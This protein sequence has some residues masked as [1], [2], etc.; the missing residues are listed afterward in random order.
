M[1]NK[2]STFFK[3][4][5][6]QTLI[7]I[8]MGVLEIVVFAIMSR[9][10][11]KS[12]FGYFAALM[13]MVAVFQ[14]LS[15]AGLGSAIVQKKG[16]NTKHVSTAFTLSCLLGLIGTCV[17]FVLAPLLATLIADDTLTLPLRIMSFT[18]F[19]NALISVGNA[20]LYKSLKFKKVGIIQSISYLLSSG[21]GI[22][23]A[24]NGCGLLSIVTY[25][26]LN[27]LFIFLI[28]YLT[29][30][31]VPKIGMYKSET[32]GIVSFGGWLTMGVI[33]NNLTQQLDKLLMS[34]WL[35][36]EALGAYNRPAGFTNTISTKIN[37]IFD[38]V[39]FPMLSELQDNKDA[40]IRTFYKAVGLL[41]SFSIILA[42]IF[43]FHAELIIQIF[44][45]QQW[46]ELVPIM[47][48]VSISIVFNINGR[49]VDC[50]FRSLNFVKTGFY[51]RMLGVFV[52]FLALYV[53]SKF[54]VMGVAI[55]L[56]MAN[57][58]MILVKMT[59]LCLKI[60]GGLISMF[61]YWVKA[62]KPILLLSSIGTVYIA[63]IP[64]HGFIVNI[65]FAVIYA[66]IMAIEFVF[67]PRLVSDEYVATV[68][69]MVM[70]LYTKFRKNSI[71]FD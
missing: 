2:T 37:G 54:N 39:L 38:T 30:V 14:S 67:Y 25:T 41:N 56:V 23:M 66:I 36:V 33:L 16:D 65:I 27:S 46:L 63:I 59:T 32:K 43:F 8:V 49:L 51:L 24:F 62:W 6:V 18:I 19:L 26:V 42:S 60:N 52:T 55:G 47:R 48:V 45:G 12:D 17:V 57:V 4:M 20:Q 10:L 1:S 34:K 15:E 53:G 11:S 40:V 68:Y 69:P 71:I 31:K 28:L 70:K 64:N 61:T 29:T 50:F 13:G 21:I 5:S 3:G 58:I 44:F 7:T 35:S 22:I 9:L